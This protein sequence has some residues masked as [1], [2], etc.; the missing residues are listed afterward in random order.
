VNEVS[1]ANR[2]GTLVTVLL[3]A[4][5][6][7]GC[8]EQNRIDMNEE[9]NRLLQTDRDF[10]TAS[11]EHGAANAFRMYLLDDAIMFSRGRHP[12]RGRNS[13][14]EVMSAGGEDDVLEWTPRAGDVAASGDMGWTWG[15]YIFTTTGGDGLETNTY[16]KYVNIWKKNADGEWR[17]AAD[18]GNDSPPPG[19]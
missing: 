10:A 8:G 17:V 1:E 6:L 9:T 14:Y 7:N 5:F 15:E 2:T 18:I 19:E 4:A 11:L 12:V 3:T 13:I 16:G